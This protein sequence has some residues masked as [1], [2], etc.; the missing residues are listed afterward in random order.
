MPSVTYTLS[1]NDTLF[2]FFHISSLL[3]IIS[4]KYFNDCIIEEDER[5]FSK[6][7]EPHCFM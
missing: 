5:G 7:W 4:S 3:R 6:V 2:I 1:C